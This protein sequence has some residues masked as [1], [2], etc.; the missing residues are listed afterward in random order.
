MHQKERTINLR[1][2][3]NTREQKKT[4]LHWTPVAMEA[5][6]CSKRIRAAK[7]LQLR[8]TSLTVSDLLLSKVDSTNKWSLLEDLM[9]MFCFIE[10]TSKKN[11]EN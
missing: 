11:R 3:H 7:Q 8:G 9:F 10:H 4:W 1:R 2:S 5:V 6:L